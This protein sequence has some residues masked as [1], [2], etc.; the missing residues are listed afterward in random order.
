M[1]T[2]KNGPPPISSKLFISLTSPSNLT[3]VLEAVADDEVTV[4]KYQAPWCRTCRAMAP[5][6]DKQAKKYGDL[7]YYSL[8][9]YR[10][11]KAAGE[12]MHK[13]FVERGAKAL[14]FVEVYRGS[15]LIEAQTI[16][17]AGVEIFSAAVGKALEAAERIREQMREARANGSASLRREAERIRAVLGITPPR[18]LPES[19]NLS[20]PKIRAPVID[21]AGRRR[22]GFNRFAAAIQ[23]KSRARPLP[24]RSAPV[25]GATGPRGKR[26][27]S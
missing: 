26:G 7:N 11:G 13:F 9:C 18:N 24:R 10:N 15:E 25:R 3:A 5:V 6:L 20:T 23:Q 8:E 22:G 4:V 2:K 14:P 21:K 12:R 17:P 1:A 27:Y 16:P 19:V